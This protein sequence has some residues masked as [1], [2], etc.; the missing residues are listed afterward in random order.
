M[1]TPRN[2][3]D[4]MMGKPKSPERTPE[5]LGA[6]VVCARETVH[7][8]GICLRVDEKRTPLCE[9]MDED[10]VRHLCQARHAQDSHAE[11]SLADTDPKWQ[12]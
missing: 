9:Y 4:L 10:G 2:L 6:C 8:C 11:P 3:F 5:N 7:R 12:G 1:S